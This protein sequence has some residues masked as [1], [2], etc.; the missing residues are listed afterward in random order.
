[1]PSILRSRVALAAL[2][3]VFLIPIITSSLR[4]LTHVLTC[5][6][7]VETPFTV[8]IEPGSDPIVLSA[9]QIVAGET[10]ELCGGLE[11]DLQAR[12]VEGNRVALTLV[13]VNETTEPW[14]GTIN[15]RLDRTTIPVTIGRIPAGGEDAETVVLNLDDGESEIAGSLLI[16]P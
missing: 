10:T 13:I 2:V 12:A 4:G 3:G 5:S 6:E 8:V 11:V 7:A 1:M 9:R 14:R 15:L 16:G